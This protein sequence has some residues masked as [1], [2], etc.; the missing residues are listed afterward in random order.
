[1]LLFQKGLVK[2]PTKRPPT[3]SKKNQ[4]TNNKL[5]NQKSNKQIKK[6]QPQ[7]SDDIMYTYLDGTYSCTSKGDLLSWWL[8]L[9]AL[10][11]S[12][13]CCLWSS[14]LLSVFCFVLSSFW[15]WA[16]FLKT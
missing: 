4:K 12:G 15:R 9:I 5:Q 10:K 14:A 2:K 11:Y 6:P 7:I 8:T 3:P 13:L 16:C 1:M